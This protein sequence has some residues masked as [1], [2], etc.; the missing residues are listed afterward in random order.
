MFVNGLSS[1]SHTQLKSHTQCVCVYVC[2]RVYSMPV[3]VH[4][5]SCVC[6]SVCACVAGSACPAVS[7]VCH[8]MCHTVEG[9]RIAVVLCGPSTLVKCILV[10]ANCASLLS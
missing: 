8:I 2:T 1:T 7:Y 9:V 5:R 6:I 4:V 3:D 10:T